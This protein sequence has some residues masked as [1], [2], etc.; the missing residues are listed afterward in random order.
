MI[1]KVIATAMADHR[2]LADQA[3]QVLGFQKGGLRDRECRGDDDQREQQGMR[4]EPACECRPRCVHAAGAP[5]AW[6]MAAIDV[7]AASCTA[8]RRPDTG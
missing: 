1:T 3:D 2:R 8:T 6:V 4:R 7:S 5:I